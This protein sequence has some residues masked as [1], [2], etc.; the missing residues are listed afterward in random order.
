MTSQ[1]N[2][3]K[4]TNIYFTEFK[5]KDYNFDIETENITEEELLTLLLSI[6]E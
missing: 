6:I 1:S 3:C 5:F 4:Y 2:L